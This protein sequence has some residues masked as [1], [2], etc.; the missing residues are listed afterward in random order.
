[1]PDEREPAGG[2]GEAGPSPSEALDLAA[3]RWLEERVD[4]LEP[5]SVLGCSAEG[6]SDS[7]LR[8]EIDS[9]LAG[10][11]YLEHALASV[12]GASGGDPEPLVPRAAIP[13]NAQRMGNYYL[14]GELGRGAMGLVYRAVHPALD[15]EVALKMLPPHISLIPERVEW[16]RK[17]AFLAARLT[18]P[19]IAH[20]HDVGCANDN[21]FYTMELIRGRSL[22]AVLSALRAAGTDRI[23]E[24]HL[25]ILGTRPLENEPA[26]LRPE[27]RYVFH[28]VRLVAEL[29][30]ALEYAHRQ[31]VLHRDLKPANI[32]LT[33]GG[34]PKITDFGLATRLDVPADET[35]RMGIGTPQYMPPE[36]FE[37]EGAPD[38]RQDVYALGVILYELVTLRLPY[39]GNTLGELMQA[40][41]RGEHLPASALNH[42]VDRELTSDIRKAMHP[43]PESRYPDAGRFAQDLQSY[44]VGHTGSVIPPPM[45]ARLLRRIRRHLWKSIAIAVS[46]L[47][48]VELLI[49]VWSLFFRD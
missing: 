28:V 2:P 8:R 20:I 45:L 46:I 22:A 7:D 3:F 25:S 14:L 30:D 10:L 32:V 5:E 38:A 39:D 47:A 43:D 26:F 16:F 4:P 48:V 33:K 42:A 35:T 17:E 19:A 11:R 49:L 24:A 12:A 1:M 40:I 37:V 18:H 27:R 15:R 29:A 9:Q 13:G 44:L 31:G 41:S 23:A 34:H 21:W 6:L 36:A